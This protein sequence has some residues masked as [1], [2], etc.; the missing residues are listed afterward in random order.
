M[1]NEENLKRTRRSST[2]KKHEDNSNKRKSS[3]TLL[4]K[5]PNINEN[6]KNSEVSSIT[7]NGSKNHKLLPKINDSSKV[8]KLIPPDD[9]FYDEAENLEWAKQI[10]GNRKQE[11]EEEEPKVTN[12]QLQLDAHRE[13]SMK[14]KVVKNDS[15]YNPDDDVAW[16]EVFAPVSKKIKMADENGKLIFKSLLNQ[17]KITMTTSAS[18]QS[19]TSNQKS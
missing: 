7:N 11:I 2:S 12:Q 6:S 14:T 16:A 5:S 18:P 1:I 9:S 13:K 15:F 19:S 10:L 3:P 4:Q 17:L 8:A